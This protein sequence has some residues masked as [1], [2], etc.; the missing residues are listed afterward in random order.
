LIVLVLV[1]AS[2]VFANAGFH[3]G[4]MLNSVFPAS[5]DNVVRDV[6]QDLAERAGIRCQEC[7]VSHRGDRQTEK[8]G[9]RSPARRRPGYNMK[10]VRRVEGE[11]FLGLEVRA[12]DGTD[13]D[14]VTNVITDR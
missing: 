12:N 4:G 7:S 8:L 14:R 9:R 2:T 3:S 5:F 6:R 13:L 1:P 10:G 11:S